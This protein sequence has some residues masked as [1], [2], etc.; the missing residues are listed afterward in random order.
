MSVAVTS[1]PAT[2]LPGQVVGRPMG[3]PAILLCTQG[4]RFCGHTW[5][6][7]SRRDLPEKLAERRKHE[8]NCLG[9]LIVP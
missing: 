9:G 8:E 5:V 3:I 4:E 1:S 2:A 6:A 7:N